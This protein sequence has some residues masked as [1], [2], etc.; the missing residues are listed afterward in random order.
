LKPDGAKSSQDPVEKNPSH[1]RT[2]GVT[3]GVGPEFQRQYRKKKQKNITGID[4]PE[5]RI[6][7]RKDFAI[8]P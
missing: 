2:G 3:Q 4:M 5:D 6:G 1:K 8:C 7:W